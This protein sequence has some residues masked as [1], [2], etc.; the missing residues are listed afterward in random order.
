M[1]TF[2]RRRG[3]WQVQIRRQ[4]AQPLSKTFETKAAGERWARSIEREIDEGKTVGRAAV[5][6]LGELIDRYSGEMQATRPF[7]R[8]KL[9][10]LAMLSREVGATRLRDLTADAVIEFARKRQAEGAG[11]VTVAMDLSYLAV[12]LR[13]ARALWRL[14]VNDTAVRDA[15]EALRMVRMVGKSRARTRRP[16]PEETAALV[17]HWQAKSRQAIPL[18]DV[19]LFAIASGMR[20]SEICSIRWDDLDGRI[21]LVR[22]RKDPRRKQGNDQRVPLL[23]IGDRDPLPIIERQPRTPDPRIF[24]YNPH[25]V[26]NLITRAV[27][28][29][30]IHDLHAHDC[31][32]EFASYAFEHGYSIEQV[33]LC[34]GH[35]DWASLRRYTNLHPENLVRL[36]LARFPEASG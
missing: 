6:T 2:R 12:I 9:A 25:S 19:W 18:A 15:R 17:A 11:P 33:A 14:Q 3:K 21:I 23:R 28:A 10:T 27:R 30:G 4:G 29:L 35:K 36:S 31:R 26:S 32:H 13:T 8:S 34:T 16:T 5:G 7:G 22:D 20:L 1:A 24:P